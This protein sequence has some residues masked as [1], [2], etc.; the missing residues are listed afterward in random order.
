MPST[1]EAL[2]R[3]RY[4]AYTRRDIDYLSR[5]LAPEM[6]GNF[7]AASSKKWAE[8]AQFKGLKM[9]ATEMGGP[10][11][12]TGTVE[13]MAT[14]EQNGENFDH[15]EIS[16]FRKDEQ[17]HWHYVDGDGHSHRRKLASDPSQNRLRINSV[18]GVRG[19]TPTKPG[20]NDSCPCGSGKKFKTCC[21][22]T[23]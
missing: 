7:Q 8:E 13:F 18:T 23:G 21:G 11:D 2:M 15:H 3:S 1:A 22:R 20:R 6:R 17:G 12:C 19:L 9:I 10:A 5:T 16:R 14:F 4:V